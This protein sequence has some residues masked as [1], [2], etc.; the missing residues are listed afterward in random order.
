MTFGHKYNL[1]K[2]IMFRSCREQPVSFCKEGM[3][4]ISTGMCFG[5]FFSEMKFSKD[6]HIWTT[7]SFGLE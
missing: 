6:I 3:K 4:E 1:Q 5:I 2:I 7:T